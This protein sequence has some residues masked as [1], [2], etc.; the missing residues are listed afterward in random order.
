M[1]RLDYTTRPT[2]VRPL[3]LLSDRHLEVVAEL[4][5]ALSPASPVPLQHGR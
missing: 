3:P 4:S 5:S 1:L 2:T